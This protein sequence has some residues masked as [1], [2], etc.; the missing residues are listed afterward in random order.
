MITSLI[1]TKLDQRTQSL[2]QKPA[3]QV[4]LFSRWLDTD[5]DIVRG[6]YTQTPMDVTEQV[7]SASINLDMETDASSASVTF[8]IDKLPLGIFYNSIIV[9]REGDELVDIANWPTTFTGWRIGQPGSS[10]TLKPFAATPAQG[11]GKRG[12]VRQVTVN[13]VS[14]ER[15]FADFEITSDGVWL[16]NSKPNPQPN[17]PR[18]DYDDVGLI[19][20]E[21]ATDSSWGMGLQPDEVQIGPLPYRIEKQLQFVQIPVWEALMEL[22]QVLHFVPGVNGEGRVVVRDRNITKASVRQYRSTHIAAISQ[23]DASFTQ[24][25]AVIVKGLAKD[26]TEVIKPDQK[27]VSI[28][29]TFGFFDPHMQFESNWGNDEQQT[30][31]VKIGGAVTDGNGKT[32]ES[33]RIRKFQTEGFITSVFPPDITD[34][35]EFYYKVEIENDTL[36][37]IG[38]LA[39]TFAGYVAGMTIAALLTPFETG[40]PGNRTTVDPLQVVAQT[41]ASLLLLGGLFV[42]QQI[43]NFQFEIWGVPFETVYEELRHDAILAQ[44]SQISGGQ[45]FREWER[46]DIEIK[47]YIFSTLADSPVP[48]SGTE[49]A[50]TN[51]GIET[52]AVTE[53]AIQLAQQGS[54]ELEM[55]RDILLEPADIITDQDSG[56]RYFVKSI[57]RELI[58]GESPSTQQITAFRVP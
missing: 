7:Q 9:I 32:H 55:V 4:L 40:T 39:A 33:P 51:P 36:L 24:V 14:R 23:P 35:N 26:L 49:P 50:V 58:R 18:D 47:N 19:A 3:Y 11:Q 31:R 57:T 27:L 44:F 46:K 56:F 6:T 29:G 42:L 1:G 28:D 48:A 45:P 38:L 54:R 30:Y 22:L 37:V 13:F 34:A 5:S 21:I 16:P 12:G 20:K 53:L 52:F 41:A 15:Q 25:N 10:E 2:Q 17:S 8:A 43:A